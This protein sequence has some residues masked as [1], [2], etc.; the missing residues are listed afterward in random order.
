M[1]ND[2]WW[3]VCFFFWLCCLFLLLVGGVN[4]EGILGH[5]EWVTQT[6]NFAVNDWNTSGAFEG[7]GHSGLGHVI[8]VDGYLYFF[9]GSPVPF[10]C[11]WYRMVQG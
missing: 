5:L 8:F 7:D 1:K 2:C 3:F 4:G 10:T 11:Q 6:S 9:G